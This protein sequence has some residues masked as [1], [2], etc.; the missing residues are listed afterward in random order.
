MSSEVPVSFLKYVV[1]VVAVIP[2]VIDVETNLKDLVFL[3]KILYGL[4]CR[5]I[6]MIVEETDLC[7]LQKLESL[8]FLSQ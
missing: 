1:F 3:E 5:K 4:N 8:L 2:S 6:L 7:I